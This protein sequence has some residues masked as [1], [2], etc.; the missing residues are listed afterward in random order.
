MKEFDL[1]K[2]KAGHPVCTRDG[3]KAR[4]I[5]FDR[6]S[7]SELPIVALVEYSPDHTETIER[8]TIDGRYF[9]DQDNDFDLMLDTIKH[10][11]WINIRKFKGDYY[12]AGVFETKHIAKKLTKR[13]NIATIKITWEE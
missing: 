4:I 13:G 8:Y 6:K 10:E 12:A 9:G 5:S 7:N 2:A 11:G 1:E 3:R